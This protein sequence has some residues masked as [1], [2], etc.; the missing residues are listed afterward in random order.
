MK[1]FNRTSQV[2]PMKDQIEAFFNQ[3]K[4]N[5]QVTEDNEKRTVLKT[6]VSLDI[7]NSDVFIVIH[8]GIK[9]VEIFAISPTNVPLNK[10][11]EVA[12]FLDIA[13]YISYLGNLQLNHTDGGIRCKTYFCYGDESVNQQ[14]IND[15]FYESINSLDRYIPGV[16]KIIYG[17]KDADSVM[18]EINGEINPLNN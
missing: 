7:G 4:F 16:M 5:Y 18:A 1:L 6:G 10:R 12:K 8:H 3:I 14:I 15:N 17:G 9:L 2:K 13:D 11:K